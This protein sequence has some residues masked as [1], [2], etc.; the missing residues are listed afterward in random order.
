MHY[1]NKNKLYLRDVLSKFTF[2]QYSEKMNDIYE[3]NN[4]KKNLIKIDRAR[5]I[6]PINTELNK[7]L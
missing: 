6:N 4:T 1:I 5:Y 3:P 7:K 2:I